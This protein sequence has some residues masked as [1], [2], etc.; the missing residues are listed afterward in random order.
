MKKSQL[1]ALVGF[2]IGWGAPAG[3]L[4]LRYLKQASLIPPLLFVRLEWDQYAFFYWYMLL[5][6]C[7]VLTIVGFL[8][9]SSE[10]LK[11]G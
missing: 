3:A 9:G 10:D 1:F 6:T 11:N 5:G 7:L 8:L 2:L 4:G